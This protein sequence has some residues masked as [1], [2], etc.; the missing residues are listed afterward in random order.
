ML[1]S[2][3][4]MQVQNSANRLTHLLTSVECRDTSIANNLESAMSSVD[5]N[6]TEYETHSQMA[7]D[8]GL[9]FLGDLEVLSSAL[10]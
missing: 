8:G 9:Q 7:T 2:L 6:I 3:E 4:A 10:K 5:C 1:A